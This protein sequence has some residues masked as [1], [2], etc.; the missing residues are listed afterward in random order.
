LAGRGT[1]DLGARTLEFHFEPKAVNGIA[2]PFYAKGP[3]EK[4]SYGPDIRGLAKSAM[5]RLGNGAASPLDI[6]T[7]PGLS[8]KSI[9]GAAKKKNQ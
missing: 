5:E 9:L 7:Q 8:L 1:V 3:W 6:L 2:V 4:P